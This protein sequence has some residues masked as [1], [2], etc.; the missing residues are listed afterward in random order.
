MEPAL[1]VH[2]G[3]Q[4]DSPRPIEEAVLAV[5]GVRFAKRGRCDTPQQVLQAVRDADAA[6]CGNEPYTR[7]V[8][9]NAPRL[10]GVVRT[11]V[12]VDTVDLEGATAHGVLVA[13]FPDFCTLEVANHAIMLLLSC[14]KKVA[15]LD[16]ALRVA[17]WGTARSALAPMGQ[18]H[19]QTLGLIAFGNIARATASRAQAFDMRVVAYDPFVD[20]AELEA[21]GVEPVTLETLAARSD[22]VSCHVP[23][24]PHT[25]GMLGA[26]FFSSMKPTAYFVNTSRGGVINERDLIAALRQGAIAGAGLDVYEQEPLADDHPFLHMDNVVLTPHS[27]SYAD[28]TMEMLF[29]RV[30]TAALAIARGELPEH[31]ANPKVLESRRR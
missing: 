6:I 30:A 18:I 3:A 21:V 24:N 12:G 29:R 9:A 15:R 2:T 22:Y 13:N 23:L 11:G 19:G 20:A 8:F 25:Q 5:P 10:K 17:G 26:A 7:E 28:A 27:A 1:V 16:R 31:L 4:P 14:A